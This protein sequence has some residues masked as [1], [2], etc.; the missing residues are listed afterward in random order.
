[1][2]LNELLKRIKSTKNIELILAGIL[3]AIILLVFL[4]GFTTENQVEQT[5]SDYVLNYEKQIEKTL[6]QISGVKDI[7]IA[8]SFENGVE[9]IYAYETNEKTTGEVTTVT[10]E[11]IISSGEPILLKELAPKIQGVLVVVECNSNPV[12]KFEIT[13]A[14]TTLL[15]VS[16]EQINVILK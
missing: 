15:N 2:K 1:M 14:L 9:K 10:T 16:Q 11:L 13:K 3:C 8:I 12:V 6:K 5:F 7:S 4:F